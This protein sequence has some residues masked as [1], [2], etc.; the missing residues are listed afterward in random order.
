[1]KS[2]WERIKREPVLLSVFVSDLVAVAIQFGMQISNSQ[3]SSIIA[4]L[5]SF[6][7]IMGGGAVARAKAVPLNEVAIYKD[8]SGQFVTG[9]VGP[10]VK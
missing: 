8:S 2:L 5:T 7:L 1:M 6:V 3:T 4:I 10:A 9:P